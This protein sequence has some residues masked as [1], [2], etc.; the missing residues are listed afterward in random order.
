VAATDH[1]GVCPYCGEPILVTARKCK[2]CGEILDPDLKTH[3]QVQTIEATSKPWKLA[4]LIGA[5]LMTLGIFLLCAG[6]GGSGAGM[7]VA[8][9]FVALPGLIIYLVAR[10]GAWWYHG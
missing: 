6:M 3:R 4:Q 8:G 5:L 9:A 10:V 1:N 7:G 2:H